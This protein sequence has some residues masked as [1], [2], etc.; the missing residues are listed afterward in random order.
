MNSAWKDQLRRALA[1][2][3]AAPDL[4]A[5]LRPAAV[6][7]LI[8]ERHGEF[9]IPLIERTRGQGVHSG[10]LA[11]PGGAV[12][13]TD[14]TLFDAA[15]REAQEEVGIDPTIV[16]I[17]GH[18]PPVRVSISGF[19]VVPFVGVA[20]RPPA[21]FPNDAEVAAIVYLP[22]S[23]LADPESVRE[24]PNPPGSLHPV[25]YEYSLPEGRLWGATARMMHNLAEA[26]TANISTFST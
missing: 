9:V 21:L 10:Q 20:A 25:M 3:Q 13:S 24:I 4:P 18:L 2:A 8:F 26:L 23:L 6:L 19:V 12:E 5:D 15:M 11:L 16:E 1:P 22:L 7:A 17:L 14:H